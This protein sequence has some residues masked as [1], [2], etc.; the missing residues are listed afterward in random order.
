M[1]V[2]LTG[3]IFAI[4]VLMYV[5]GVFLLS[6][7]LE[8]NSIMDI[9]YGPAF[10]VASWVT[11]YLTQSW[12]MTA[13]MAAGLVTV[14]AT[15]L[16]VR[17]LRKNWGKPE[18]ARYAAWREAWCQNGTLYFIIRSYLQ[19]NVLQGLIIVLV[20]SPVIIAISQL[21]DSPLW[22][23]ILGACIFALG[24]GYEAL[25]DYQLDRFI[26]RKQAGI[27]TRNL[28]T[29]GLFRYSRRP[30]YFGETLVW[31]GLFIVALPLPAGWLGIIGP[32]TITFIVTRVTGPMLEDM[33]L[34]KYPEQY[35]E[36]M[37]RTS[38]LIPWPPQRSTPTEPAAV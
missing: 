26:A 8:D 15:R 36:Y 24:L 27:E 21:Q 23:Q 2:L 18:D 11:I 10:A 28:M 7:F 17:I 9:A 19:V 1:S 3:A 13:L 34:E 38:Y 30:N 32:V 35:R 20:A 31:W 33:F 5:T 25:A 14:W 29:D 37:K 6:R 4:I 22:A 12:S 16:F